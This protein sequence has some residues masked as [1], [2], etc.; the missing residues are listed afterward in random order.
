[1]ELHNLPTSDQQTTPEQEEPLPSQEKL[2]GNDAVEE[3]ED[4]DEQDKQ[5]K[6]DKPKKP[7]ETINPSQYGTSA[8]LPPFGQS[9]AFPAKSGQGC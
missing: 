2:V 5:E 1:M 7:S 8:G 6:Q 9:S 4:D 3:E